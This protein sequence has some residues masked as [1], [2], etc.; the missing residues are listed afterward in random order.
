L[1]LGAQPVFCD[2]DPDTLALTPETVLRVLTPKTKAVM[3]VHFGGLAVDVSAIRA[4]LPPHIAIIE[5]AAHAFG[6]FY[7]DGRAVGASGNL[8]CFS[9]YANKNL[10][11]AEGGAIALGDPML[12]ERLR[13]IRQHGLPANA[14]MRFSHPQEM[15]PHE[16]LELG[17]KMNY[18]DLQASIGRVQL[19]RQTLFRARRM[20]IAECYAAGLAD[21][22]VRL[23]SKCLEPHHARHLFCLKLPI[24][25]LSVSRDQFVLA[26]RQRNIGASIHYAPLHQMNFYRKFSRVSLP[27]TEKIAASIITL[28]IGAAMNVADAEY[29]VT[30]CLQLL[31]S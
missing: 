5:D 30:H 10:S 31:S 7:P 14:W 29:V 20:A 8:V 12:A 19:R 13:S 9:F 17:F 24:E 26:L 6:A 16:L 2:V 21:T 3:V 1:Y 15:P 18:T 28:P 27:I 4:V 11:T 23:Q 25:T 22:K